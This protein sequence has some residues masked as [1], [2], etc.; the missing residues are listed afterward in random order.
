MRIKWGELLPVLRPTY[1]DSLHRLSPTEV[2]EAKILSPSTTP[3]LHFLH[4]LS[5]AYKNRDRF[6]LEFLGSVSSALRRDM[7]SKP[8][9]TSLLLLPQ[10]PGFCGTYMSWGCRP[11]G[12]EKYVLFESVVRYTPSEPEEVAGVFWFRVLLQFSS[13]SSTVSMQ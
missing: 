2:V 1:L 11:L 3:H 7:A 13:C 5:D 6:W 8:L 9:P 10:I 12:C 4:A